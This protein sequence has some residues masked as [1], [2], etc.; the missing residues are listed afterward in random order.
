[1]KR[2]LAI[3]ALLA[4]CA[5]AVT[6]TYIQGAQ[7]TTTS[8]AFTSANN[9]GNLLL[10][11]V[12]NN[13]YVGPLSVSDSAGNTW[14][15]VVGPATDGS[16][17]AVQ[18]FCAANAKA[19]ANTV[20]VAGTGG[21]YVDVVLAE[22]SGLGTTCATDGTGSA[23][24]DS[25][26]AATGNFSVSSGDLLVVMGIMG[27]GGATAG[28]GFT[29]RG[30]DTFSMMEDQIASGTTANGTLTGSTHQWA[31]AGVGFRPGGGAA[32][33]PC[34]LS[35]LGAGGCTVP[36]LVRLDAAGLGSAVGAGLLDYGGSREASDLQILSVQVGPEIAS[37][38]IVFGDVAKM[39]CTAMLP[40]APFG[41]QGLYQLQPDWSGRSGTLLIGLPAAALAAL[42]IGLGFG[43]ALER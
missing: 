26:T 8:V 35:T 40:C 41:T 32:H 24:G 25:A 15:S 31:I 19:G 20:T 5:V 17:Q 28:S 10:T 9:A 16:S 23:T 3:L 29:S 4:S 22:Y 43:I 36:L 39:V 30:T 1:M 18:L 12:E 21:N 14:T 42:G 27:A 11:A 6:P 33:R 13:A 37:W 7:A 38:Q 34:T 2:I